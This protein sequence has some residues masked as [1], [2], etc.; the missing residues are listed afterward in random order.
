M[1]QILLIFSLLLLLG[2]TESSNIFGP[3][4]YK[5][6]PSG[7]VVE[8]VGVWSVKL[9]W[10]DRS[11]N[12]DGF[13]IDR[14][15]VGEDWEKKYARLKANTESYADTLDS[16]GGKVVYRVYAHKDGDYTDFSENTFDFSLLCYSSN[17][18]SA[19]YMDVSI[20]NQYIYIS[21]PFS[22]VDI[23]D[24]RYPLSVYQSYTIDA[25]LISVSEKYICLGA[26]EWVK[27]YTNN[28]NK[29]EKICNLDDYLGLKGYLSDIEI[30]GE[31]LYLSNI[32]GLYMI[33]ISN[34]VE[35]II[36]FTFNR[37][38]FYENITIEDY[39][40]YCS[41]DNGLLIFDIQNPNTP[42]LIGSFP[43]KVH[44]NYVISEKMLHS[45]YDGV[46]TVIDIS[47]PTYPFE[48]YSA[49]IAKVHFNRSRLY[50]NNNQLYLLYD[51]ASDSVDYLN[52]Y[53]L[54]NT[55]KPVLEKRFI[56]PYGGHNDR[57]AM[58]KV[59]KYLYFCYDGVRVYQ[60]ED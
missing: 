2:C 27:L 55:T 16:V 23:S 19:P 51:D 29:P 28:L 43:L 35:P 5:N 38:Y 9:T 37:K 1:R 48:V 22:I 34:P 24:P 17:K 42:I 18:Y 56:S 7:L 40:L 4:P 12:E 25:F 57:N 6:A 50:V 8:R 49:T 3:D 33:D 46:L 60:I 53:S 44:D 39:Y 14:K 26:S 10:T 52:I 11:D 47:N 30:S 15:Q 45:T 58:L 59:D 21:S 20:Y 32:N 13:Y 41:T 54:D 36:K 31:F